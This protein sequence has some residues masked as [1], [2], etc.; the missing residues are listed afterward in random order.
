LVRR[1]SETEL[2][3]AE[4]DFWTRLDVFVSLHGG[5]GLAGMAEG[6]FRKRPGRFDGVLLPVV[7]QRRL[8]VVLFRAASAGLG[9]R[10]N[11]IPL[12]G[13]FDHS[14]TVLADKSVGSH[15]AA[16]LFALG[17]VCCDFEFLHF[18]TG[19]SSG[20]FSAKAGWRRRSA[21]S[22]ESS[23]PRWSMGTSW[24]KS[25]SLFFEKP[26]KNC[27]C[28]GEKLRVSFA[29]ETGRTASCPCGGHFQQLFLRLSARLEP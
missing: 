3:A 13:N 28:I 21:K 7:A 20:N 22:R 11:T 6:W 27:S 14:S 2:D 23:F 18:C 24:T 26:Q 1:A 15:V 5:L 25:F 29:S 12:G 16:A 8:V 10:R 4:L 9:L 19:V 17:F